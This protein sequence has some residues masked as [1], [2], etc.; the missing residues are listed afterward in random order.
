MQDLTYALDSL[1][2]A[3]QKKLSKA[4]LS[5]HEDELYRWHLNDIF[6]QD[7]AGMDAWYK[8]VQDP[9]NLVITDWTPNDETLGDKYYFTIVGTKL[10][11]LYS[12]KYNYFQKVGKS[13]GKRIIPIR[14][15]LRND[16]LAFDEA[17]NRWC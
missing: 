1:T 2:Y 4:I 9:D 17:E 12:S 13:V 15:L 3:L 5:L 6:W 11:I 16:Q 14:P 7:G 10:A 8:L